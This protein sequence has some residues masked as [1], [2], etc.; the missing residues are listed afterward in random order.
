M[1]NLIKSADQFVLNSKFNTLNRV[2]PVDIAR[3]ADPY[4]IEI[5]AKLQKDLGKK[6]FRTSVITGAGAST[7]LDF[8]A[9]IS[10]TDKAISSIVEDI[11]SSTVPKKGFSFED[12]VNTDGK[13]GLFLEVQARFSD[14]NLS[15]N[16]NAFLE[17]EEIQYFLFSYAIYN[18]KLKDVTSIVK[19]MTDS[20]DGGISQLYEFVAVKAVQKIIE[21][22]KIAATSTSTSDLLEAAKL[23]RFSFTETV[24][25]NSL[26]KLIE[27]FVFGSKELQIISKLNEDQD[28]ELTE[29][30]I[31]LLLDFVKKSKITITDGNSEIFLLPEVQRIRTLGIENFPSGTTVNEGD[32]FVDYFTEDSAAIEIQRD[33][34]LCAAQLYFVMTIG[35]EMDVFNV[36]HRIATRYLTTGSV[37]IRSRA[38]LEDLQLYVFSDRFRDL[39]NNKEHQRIRLEELNMFQVQVFGG[40]TQTKLA[41]GMVVN[42]EFETLWET[43]MYETAKYLQKVEKSENPQ[44]FVSRQNIAQAI[45]DL[46]YNLSTYCTG[47]TKVLAPVANRELDFVMKRILQN[48]EIIRQIAP[49]NSSSVWK[50]IERILQEWKGKSVNV[51]A[52]RNKAVYGHMILQAIANYSAAMIDDDAEFSRFINTVEAFIIANSQLEGQGQRKE[53]YNGDENESDG[54]GMVP[55]HN[56]SPE[57]KQNDDWDF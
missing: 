53:L 30:E 41:E 40:V 7:G 15:F 13:A 38:L 1:P 50:V 31:S 21:D 51:V 39:R 56:G 19:F 44:F 25:Y 8:D 35:Y 10:D 54:Y 28:L 16:A 12:K 18:L 9:T 22:E 34:V 23:T 36:V 37:D 4:A 52:L 57:K 14:L 49:R 47:M 3:R 29:E 26:K 43:L 17:K 32:F 20:E 27:K 42:S 45:E 6:C 33:N 11:S 55:S 5:I 24:F 46:Q 2:L 48:D